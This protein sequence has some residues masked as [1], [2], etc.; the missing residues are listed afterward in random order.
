MASTGADSVDAVAQDRDGDGRGGPR[1]SLV[2][3]T[4]KRDEDLAAMFAS[5]RAQSVTDFE[6][7]IIDQNSDDRVVRYVDEARS[8][9][10]SVRHVKRSEPGA[11]AA[12]NAGLALAKGQFVAFPDDDCWYEPQVV[13][14]ALAYFDATPD[15][16][17]LIG[18]WCEHD[19]ARTRPG[20]TL[21][22]ARWRV[23][24]G[25][26]VACFALFFRTCVLRGVGGFA[27]NFG[28]GRYFGCAEE[29][30]LAFRL[31]KNGT[32]IDYVPDIDIH[33][34]HADMPQ[35]TAA[36]RR[37]NRLYGRGTGGVLAKHKLPLW[38]IGRGLVGPFVQALKGPNPGEALVLSVYTVW[39]RIEGL[40]GWWMWGRK[41]ARWS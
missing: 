6:L 25:G 22:P 10:L 1:L 3:P 12:R 14:R 5:M 31:I 16:G 38:V 36:Q 39:G 35:L 4:L 24:K 40:A 41:D 19:P 13:E 27:E 32:R 26:H 28:P 29:E 8:T 18:H 11:T 23:F 33:H 9:G 7:I 34:P 37:R 30:D 20:E 17:A 21:D 2:V 15:V